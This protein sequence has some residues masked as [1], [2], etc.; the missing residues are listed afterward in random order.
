M[1]RRLHDMPLQQ[2]LRELRG[3]GTDSECEVMFADQGFANHIGVCEG[4]GW[5][6]E[7]VGEV[8]GFVRSDLEEG[9]GRGREGGEGGN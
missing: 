8:E 9:G 1:Q 4:C 6:G 7:E 3:P 2:T 5:V